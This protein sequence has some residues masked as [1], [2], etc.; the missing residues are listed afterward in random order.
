MHSSDILN[1]YL[2]TKILIANLVALTIQAIGHLIEL[3]E[4]F[5]GVDRGLEPDLTG[6]AAGNRLTRGGA[7]GENLTR[8]ADVEDASVGRARS[9]ARGQSSIG[10]SELDLVEVGEGNQ[11]ETLLEVL[12]N[13]LGIGL[14]K[15]TLSRSESVRNALAGGRVL[16]DG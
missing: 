15:V 14:A 2:L 1:V 10:V 9:A 8:L 7:G 11:R 16:D 6:V 4:S 12:N 5:P 3:S 13:P